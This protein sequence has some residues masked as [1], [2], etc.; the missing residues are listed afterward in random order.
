MLTLFEISTLDH[1]TEVMFNVMDAPD[2]V[3]DNASYE[4]QWYMCFLCMLLVIFSYYLL[5]NTLICGVIK[6]RLRSES[7]MRNW[8]ATR[9]MMPS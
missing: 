6:V 1:W 4:N 9:R 2:N 5:M 3:G 7:M 8:M